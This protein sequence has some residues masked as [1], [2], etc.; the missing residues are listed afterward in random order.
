M[1]P[2][3]V[4]KAHAEL[5]SVVGL[6]RLPLFKDLDSLVYVNAIVKEAL[7]W[8]N[9]LPIG[10][11]HSTTSDDEFRGYFVPSDTMLIPNIW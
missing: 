6:H 9:A 3:V 2:D 5:D 4:R 11:P 7:R 8:H 10:V 1:N